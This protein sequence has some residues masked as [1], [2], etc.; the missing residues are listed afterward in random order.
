MTDSR[1]L[2]PLIV[3]DVAI[4]SV[5]EGALK[6]LLVQRAQDPEV[7][8][9]ALTGGILKPNVDNSLEA[10]A[11]RI[12]ID[13]IG[14]DVSHV[15]EV[16]TFSGPNRDARGW[17]VSILF[18]A[19][20]PQDQLNVIVRSKVEALEWAVASKPGDRMAFDHATQLAVAVQVLKHKVEQNALPLH[21]MPSRFTLTELQRT[22]EAILGH[23]LDKGVFRRRLRGSRD[24]VEL[25]EFVGGAQRPA[26]LYQAREGFR[27]ME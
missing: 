27:F 11:R 13:K 19:L 18:Y 4:F 25:G 6:V 15:E 14:V 20:L 7:R 2:Y 1:E 24:L 22:C 5:E 23:S 9:W 16:R 10:A 26:Q 8:R 12:L 21:L 17:S 3:V